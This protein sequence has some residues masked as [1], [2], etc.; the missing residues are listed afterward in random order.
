M[1]SKNKLLRG[2]STQGWSS[3]NERKTP[4]FRGCR[5]TLK[6]TPHR[7]PV[8]GMYRNHILWK[9]NRTRHAGLVIHILVA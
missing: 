8:Q 1:T 9:A 7:H 5:E 2:I 6:Y 3:S 4:S